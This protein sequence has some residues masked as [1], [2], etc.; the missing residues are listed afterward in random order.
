MKKNIL[1]IFGLVV[2]MMLGVKGTAIS[3]SGDP[4]FE[5]KSGTPVGSIHYWGSSKRYR[6]MG[7]NSVWFMNAEDAEGYYPDTIEDL[8]VFRKSD[9]DSGNY[10]PLLREQNISSKVAVMMSG[11]EP[12]VRFMCKIIGTGGRFVPYCFPEYGFDLRVEWNYK[13]GLTNWEEVWI[14]VYSTMYLY[15]SNGY[16]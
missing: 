11:I 7:T 10:A 5:I 1:L 3:G 15:R 12:S 4:E 16:R 2:L 8:I 6:R 13:E 9:Y 14:P